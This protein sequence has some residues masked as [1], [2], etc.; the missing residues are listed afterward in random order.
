LWNQA[1]HPNAAKVFANWIASKEGV[2]VYAPIDGSAPVR[3]DV[4]ASAWLESSLIPKPG[5]DYFDV[6]DYTYV[7]EQRQPIARFYASLEG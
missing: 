1:P 5:G 2:S 3:T 4:D 7:V 6:Y